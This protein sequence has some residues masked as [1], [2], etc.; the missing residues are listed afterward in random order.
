M[1]KTVAIVQARLGSTRLP[2]KMLLDL[3]GKPLLW[4]V[5]HRLRASSKIDSVV[6][7]TT[8]TPQDDA[9]TNFCSEYDFLCYRGSE[10]DV[11]D[12]F[13]QTAKYHEAD[14]VVRVTGDCPL[15]DPNIVDLI[16][17]AF[18]S[19][20]CDYASNLGSIDP[21]GFFQ[22]RTFPDGLDAEAFSLQT[23]KCAWQ[24]AA[25]PSDR[26][27][28]TPYI[29]KNPDKFRV[30]QVTQK[31]DLSSLRWTLDGPEDLIFIRQ[32][33]EALYSPKHHFLT[34]DVLNLLTMHP[35]LNEINAGM[36]INEGYRESLRRNNENNPS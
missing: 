2:K 32:I 16:I 23:L 5:I 19:Q 18:H 3:V 20:N 29:Y 36:N 22:G 24:E 10:D 15:I 28:V 7:A 27:H 9:I 35:E 6:I 8:N 26:E 1:S 4:H 31:E 11:L 33:F 14:T 25:L 12:R 17:T 30:F 21:N 34:P 13:Y